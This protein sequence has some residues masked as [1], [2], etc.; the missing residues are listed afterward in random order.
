MS[1][2]TAIAMAIT[3]TEA[4]PVV[5][6]VQDELVSSRIAQIA[7]KEARYQTEQEEYKKRLA[8]FQKEREEFTPFYKKY[9]E[10][11]EMKAKDPVAAI[12]LM[13]F[14]DTDYLNFI[15]AQEDKSSPEEKAQKIAQAEIAKF[16]EEQESLSKAETEKRNA[17]AISQ[18]QKNIGITI[19]TDAEKFELCN[20]YGESAEALIYNTIRDAFQEDVKENPDAEPMTTAEAAELVEQYYEEQAQKMVALKK[21]NKPKDGTQ[22]EVKKEEVASQP[23]VQPAAPKPATPPVARTL[24]NRAAPTVAATVPAKK[25]ESR[26]E[27]RARL[28]AALSAGVA[29]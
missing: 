5:E 11:E 24:T 1:K 28:C 15:A 29:P 3:P 26:E 19:K 18:L 14:S 17:E 4:P 21:L 22:L 10:F 16:K 7:K 20:F 8:E 6:P 25:M 23:Q 13:G 9:K 27:K 2:E 12:R